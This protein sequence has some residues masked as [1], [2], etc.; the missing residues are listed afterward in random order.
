MVGNVLIGALSALV[1]GGAG[2]PL[3]PAASAGPYCDFFDLAGLCDVRDALKACDAYPDACA[4][5]APPTVSP[6]P[7]QYAP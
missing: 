7:R 1:I 4:E 3:A 5:Y 2:L 6:S